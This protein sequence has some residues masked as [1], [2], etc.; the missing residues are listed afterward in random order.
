MN[1]EISKISEHDGVYKFT[2]S[3]TNV[4]F[5]NALRRTILSDI[6]TVVIH[7]EEGAET[8]DQCKISINT[9][10]LHNEIVKHRLSCIP[11]HNKEMDLPGKYVLDLDM[12]ND[13]ENMM[14][15][16]TEDFRL[17][18]KASGK[19]LVKEEVQKLFPPDPKTGYYIDFVRLRPKI[20]DTIPGEHIK[21]MA[22]FS[23]HSAKS[24]NMY[25][26]VSKCSYGNTPDMQKVNDIW[27]QHY[28][29]MSAEG[30]TKQEVEFQKKNFMLLDAQRQFVP[31]SFDFVIQTLGI[32]TNR[33]L[34]KRACAILKKKLETVGEMIEAD[35]VDILNS[36][37]S[38]DHCYDFVL[39][40][41]DYTIGK[42]IEFIVY[43]KYY[44]ADNLLSFCGFKKFHPH[45]PTSTLRLAFTNSAD[46]NEVR[47]CVKTACS[48][49][50][51][52]FEN[53][54]SK[55]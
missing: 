55:F 23:V 54:Y 46:K 17:M 42:V 10:R 30:S 31:D 6:P 28:A 1:P 3:N 25:N 5:A 52:V 27:D 22:E 32:Y 38:F 36:E 37:V 11:V 24:N 15:V 45:N 39:E 49:A 48:E 20:S 29:K 35:E 44:V 19:Y 34:V 14:Y 51:R 21:L 18:E 4:S 16:T 53:M 13:T 47:M 26:V 8:D 40:N 12:K 2:L 33:E 7:T 50:I 43:E 41:E 9:G